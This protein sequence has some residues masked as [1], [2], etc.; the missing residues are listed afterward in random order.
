MT[1]S[2]YPNVQWPNF[3][4]VT[5]MNY[6][7]PNMEVGQWNLSLQR[8]ISNQWLVS[9]NYL[10][11]KTSH[12]WTLQQ[13]NPSVFWDWNHALLAVCNMQRVR[14]RPITML[15]GGSI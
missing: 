5:A 2:L 15:A 9:A 12:M 13:L 1:V 6:D 14:Q 3:A 8:Q 7:L 4:V 10:G 11:T